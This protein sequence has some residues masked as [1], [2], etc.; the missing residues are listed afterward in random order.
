MRLCLVLCGFAVLVAQAF[1]VNRGFLCD[2]GSSA[3]IVVTESCEQSCHSG[4]PCSEDGEPK[5]HVPVKDEL[6]VTNIGAPVTTIPEPVVLAILPEFLYLPQIVTT[7]PR[8]YWYR[9][10]SPPLAVDLARTVV[11]RI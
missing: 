1:G 11:L 9:S 3:L 4:E 6:K 10:E 7:V 8:D 2:C 5:E